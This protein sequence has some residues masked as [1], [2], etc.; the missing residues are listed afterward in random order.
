MNENVET[1]KQ[2]MIKLEGEYLAYINKNGF[3]YREYAMPQ[4]GSF[5]DNYKKRMAELTAAT[6]VKPLEY[7]NKY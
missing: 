1:L 7:Y 4:A 6:G 3:N 5:M 2:E